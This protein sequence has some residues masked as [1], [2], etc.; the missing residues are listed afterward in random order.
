MISKFLEESKPAKNTYQN[1][2]HDLL[3]FF[4]S[5]AYFM[6]LDLS[7]MN[8]H[9][10][11]DA[12]CEPW[13]NWSNGNKVL[14]LYIKISKNQ[15]INFSM[16]HMQKPACHLAFKNKPNKNSWSCFSAYSH[17]ASSQ[18]KYS[19]IYTMLQITKVTGEEKK[20]HLP[21]DQHM[22]LHGA[23][24]YWRVGVAPIW[25]LTWASHK[26]LRRLKSITLGRDKTDKIRPQ[27]LYFHP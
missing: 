19:T 11:T 2:K 21:L 12:F 27:N 24:S 17:L 14:K 23:N 18:G 1:C 6:F 10:F 16:W 15:S 3:D 25:L 13:M 26:L 22:E 4:I 5:V 8:N 20:T 9:A 7:K